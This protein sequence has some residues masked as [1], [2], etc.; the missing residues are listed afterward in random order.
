MNY[1]DTD[2]KKRGPIGVLNV[3]GKKVQKQVYNEIVTLEGTGKIYL[4]LK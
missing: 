4:T 2:F 3:E 1:G